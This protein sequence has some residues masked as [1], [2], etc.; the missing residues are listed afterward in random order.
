VRSAAR[1]FAFIL[2][3]KRSTMVVLPE[4][5]IP[6]TTMK[7]PSLLRVLAWGSLTPHPFGFVDL[8]PERRCR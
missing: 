6:S 3:T 5:S 8:H 1:C 7:A 4:P 2:A